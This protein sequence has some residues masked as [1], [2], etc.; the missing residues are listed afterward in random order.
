[1]RNEKGLK[2]ATLYWQ[3][4]EWGGPVNK[5]EVKVV[6]HGTMK[7]A[8]YD[9]APYVVFFKKR[10]RK[11]RRMVIFGHDHYL[12]I[13]DG[14]GHPDVPNPY[15]RV[16]SSTPGVVV[17]R[18]RHLMVSGPW[19]DEVDEAMAGYLAEDQSRVLADY[20]ARRN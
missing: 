19:C 20:R 1:M 3:S 16:E 11:P 2:K 7:Y 4:P 12:L 9:S 8:Q 18:S 14:W 17:E 5:L 13:L 15:E 6:E 10:A